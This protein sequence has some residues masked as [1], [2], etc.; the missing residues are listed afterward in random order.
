MKQH[1]ADKLYKELIS[2]F[3]KDFKPASIFEEDVRFKDSGKV[4]VSSLSSI[5]ER[6]LSYEDTDGIIDLS[7]DYSLVEPT[8]IAQMLQ[9]N[10]YAVIG[11]QKILPS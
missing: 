1:N 9:D 2:Y 11:K 6:A 7:Q 5:E 3:D 8:E 4:E 10:K